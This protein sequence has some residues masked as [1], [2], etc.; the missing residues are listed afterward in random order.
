MQFLKR[1]YLY[2]SPMTY[3]PKKIMPCAL[4]LATKTEN[5]HIPLDTYVTELMNKA[6]LRDMSR[7]GILAVEYILTQGLRFTFDVRHPQRALKGGY[8]ELVSMAEGT[9]LPATDVSLT[10]KQIQEQMQNLPD[11]PE[12]P[13]SQSTS[14][15]VRARVNNAYGRAKE[16]LSTTALTSD[17]Y[18]HYTPSQIFLASLLLADEVLTLYYLSTKV[19]QGSPQHPKI[20]SVLRAC[21]RMLAPTPPFDRAELKRIDKKLYTCQNPEKVDLIALNKAH[22]R[23]GAQDGKLHESVAKKRKLERESSMREGDELFGPSLSRAA[24]T[25]V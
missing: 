5:W 13:L 10:S 6:K 16:T 2:N 4:F 3:H 14:E 17:A 19:P 11:K 9:A 25:E 18:F 22:K 12:G 21:A 8:L 1:F 15:L 24:G 23:D 7:D 20:V